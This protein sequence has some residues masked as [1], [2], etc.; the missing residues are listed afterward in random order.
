MEQAEGSGRFL[1]KRTATPTLVLTMIH[2]RFFLLLQPVFWA[3]LPQSTILGDEP[4]AEAKPIAGSYQI[5]EQKIIHQGGRAIIFNRTTPPQFTKPVPQTL[6][7]PSAD[8][9]ATLAAQAAKTH[10]VLAMGA[11]VYDREVTELRW[12]SGGRAHVAY[13]NIDFSLIAGMGQFETV[14]VVYS[15]MLGWGQATRASLAQQTPPKIV[16][17]LA[18]FPADYSVYFL[19]SEDVFTAQDEAVLSALDALHEYYDGHVEQI[20]AA[21]NERQSQQAARLVQEQ[22]ERDHP[23]PPKDTVLQLWPKKS[24]VYLPK[25]G[26][27]P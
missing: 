24:G 2:R 15:L 14:N 8:E 16:P 10:E 13:S 4:S 23:A 27:Q 21:Y 20:K 5:L 22:W 3:W 12:T 7:V 9:A 6:P 18:E 25:G 19:S 11:T 26:E 1:D 17:A